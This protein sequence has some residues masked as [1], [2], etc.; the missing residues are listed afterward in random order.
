M[1]ISRETPPEALSPAILSRLVAL[2]GS[3]E[4]RSEHFSVSTTPAWRDSS[5]IFGGDDS[6]VAYPCPTMRVET[7]NGILCQNSGDARYLAEALW[8]VANPTVLRD[9]VLLA[10]GAPPRGLKIQV[11]ASASKEPKALHQPSRTLPEH[12]PDAT[13]EDPEE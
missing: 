4:A 13:L 3:I 11:Q 8:L 5:S 7:T 6:R 9:L 12:V 2:L 10:Y 1:R